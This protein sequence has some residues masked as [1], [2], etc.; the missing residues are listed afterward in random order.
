[1]I[2]VQENSVACKNCESLSFQIVQI[3]RVLE[4]YEKGQIGLEGVLRQQRLPNDK[5]GLGY[6]KSKPSTSKT[7]F[8]KAGEQ[9]NKLDKAQN[10]YHHC[11][12]PKFAHF[13]F[14]E[15]F[16]MKIKSLI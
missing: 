14:Q 11:Y 16:N 4:R 2:S 3:K 10:V 15:S 5:S 6:A 7:I 1:M 13:F 9:F 8:V 12:T